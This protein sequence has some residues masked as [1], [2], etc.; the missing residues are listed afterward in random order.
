MIGSTERQIC[1]YVNNEQIPNASTL[2]KIAKTLN[3]SCDY[4]LGLDTIISYDDVYS[5]ISNNFSKMTKKQRNSL[6]IALLDFEENP[7]S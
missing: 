2:Y 1:R 6:I 7:G 5:F 4:L 3:V